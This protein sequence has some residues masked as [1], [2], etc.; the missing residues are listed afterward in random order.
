MPPRASR[1]CCHEH[2]RR[3]QAERLQHQHLLADEAPCEA[4]NRPT[5]FTNLPC[6]RFG[7]S[8]SFNAIVPPRSSATEGRDLSPIPG[9]RFKFG[10]RVRKTA[11]KTARVKGPSQLNIHWKGYVLLPVSLPFGNSPLLKQ[12]DDKNFPPFRGETIRG[13]DRPRCLAGK[14]N[15]RQLVMS[16]RMVIRCRVQ[17]SDIVE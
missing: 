3:C 13:S 15:L 9:S 17:L 5:I 1:R 11:P 4:A 12:R 16:S 8:A 2:Q 7:Y 6:I 10:A 14:V